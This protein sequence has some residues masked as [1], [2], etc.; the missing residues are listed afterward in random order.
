[1]DQRS[2]AM[3]YTA[4]AEAVGA[5]RTHVSRVLRGRS[6]V[7]REL[8]EKMAGLLGVGTEEFLAGV[9]RERDEKEWERRSAYNKAYGVA[10]RRGHENPASQARKAAGSV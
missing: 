1:M 6:G 2:H 9:E 7:S 4:I 5:S 8:A 3:S 10:R